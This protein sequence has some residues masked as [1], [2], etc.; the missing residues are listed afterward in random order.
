MNAVAKIEKKSLLADMA[1]QYSLEPVMFKE[2]VR[3]TCGLATASNEEFAAF[4]LV[5][6]THQLN[7]IT[8]EIYAFPK[9]GGGIQPIVSIDG[10][11]RLANSHPKFDG[12][13]FKDIFDAKGKLTAIQ[14]HVF[15]KDRG[16][17]TSVTEYMEE[18]AMP[19]SEAWQKWPARMLRHKAA[20]QAIR[21]AF[22]FAGIID[23]D[24]AD[25]SP[26]VET[27]RVVAPPP[28]ESNIEINTNIEDAEHEEIDA[29]GVVSETTAEPGEREFNAGEWLIR[30]ADHLNACTTP[31]E[32]ETA[33]EEADALATLDGD[34]DSQRLALDMYDAAKS[35]VS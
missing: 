14:C 16:R 33:W 2:T 15:R 20:I 18:C 4:L 32:L 28:D 12:L 26:E 27:G 7:P 6:N 1:A 17:P 5:A 3:A 13:E 29:D 23:P 8:R 19:K 30:L 25:R 24:E 10:W 11:Y 31:E 9:R 21:I 35:R 34:D 22:G